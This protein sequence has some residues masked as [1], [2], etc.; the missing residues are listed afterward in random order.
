VLLPTLLP[1]GQPVFGLAQAFL[2]DLVFF[3]LF[4]LR[5]G[6]LHRLAQHPQLGLVA[7]DVLPQFG[8]GLLGFVARLVQA[9]RQ[10]ALVLDLLLQAGQRAADLID[11]GLRGSASAALRGARARSRCGPRPR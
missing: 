4:Q 10:L 1:A 2:L 5:G 11:R 3:L 7:T 6:G 8:Q 9:L